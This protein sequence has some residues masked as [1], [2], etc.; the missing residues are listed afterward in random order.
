MRHMPSQQAGPAAGTTRMTLAAPGVPKGSPAVTTKRSSGVV[1]R[2]FFKAALQAFFRTRSNSSS[3]VCVTAM[4]RKEGGDEGGLHFA[5]CIL[6]SEKICRKW[7]VVRASE[8]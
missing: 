4:K 1:T 8:E 5:F 6:Q 3:F 7:L 2:P